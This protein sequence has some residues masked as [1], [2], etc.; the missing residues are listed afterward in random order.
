MK[1]ETPLTLKYDP[2]IL[3]S[4][5]LFVFKEYEKDP[6]GWITKNP[7]SVAEY[8]EQLWLREQSDPIHLLFGR[9]I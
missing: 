7:P 6:R 8:A 4:Y 5:I 2:N 3:H 1:M 9:I